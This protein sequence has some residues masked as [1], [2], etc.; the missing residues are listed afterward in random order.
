MQEINS[1]GGKYQMQVVVARLI[2]FQNY[3]SRCLLHLVI[4]LAIVR[5]QV[6]DRAEQTL[7]V[8]IHIVVLKNEQS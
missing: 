5:D 1:V 6:G 8:A 2:L 4:L 7:H 3:V